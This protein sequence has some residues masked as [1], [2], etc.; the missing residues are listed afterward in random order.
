MLNCPKCTNEIK[1]ID[2]RVTNSYYY[3]SGLLAKRR[4][5]CKTCG[6][7]FNTFE[8]TEDVVKEFLAAKVKLSVLREAINGGSGFS[9]APKLN[10]IAKAIEYYAKD[11]NNDAA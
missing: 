2:S 8:V 4:R 6:H 7:R 9:S 5:E 10:S 11:E 3:D 1:V